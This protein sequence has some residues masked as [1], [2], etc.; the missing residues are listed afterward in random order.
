[1]FV[2]RYGNAIADIIF[3]DAIPQAKL[4]LSFPNKANEQGMT[5][6]QYPGV[7]T[8]EYSYQ[9]TYS[10]GQIVGYR[11]HV[12]KRAVPLIN[13]PGTHAAKLQL[14]VVWGLILVAYLHV[15]PMG[16]MGCIARADTQSP[17]FVSLST[18]TPHGVHGTCR[19]T[20]SLLLSACPRVRPTGVHRTRRHANVISSTATKPFAERCTA[21]TTSTTSSPPSPSATASR[22]ASPYS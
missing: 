21:G 5:K 16:P 14:W 20:V 17:C 6:E 18:R 19:H 4:P 3:G 22:T 1:M 12:Q 8:K 15:H 10:E 9:A 13:V 2:I 7:E 11:W